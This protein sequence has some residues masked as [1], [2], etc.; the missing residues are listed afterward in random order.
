[1]EQ[2]LLRCPGKAS[3]AF[4]I[5]HCSTRDVGDAADASDAERSRTWVSTID[6][7]VLMAA[8]WQETS[9]QNRQQHQ[10]CLNAVQYK[11]PLPEH[12]SALQA[13]KNHTHEVLRLQEEPVCALPNLC[14]SRIQACWVL[15][16]ADNAKEAHCQSS[17]NSLIDDTA[18]ARFTIL[19]PA[20]L[21]GQ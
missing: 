18:F 9:P 16:I 20:C 21:K 5:G 13:I 8:C 12:P 10:H 4:R 15:W 2:I 14:A 19:A 11:R 17:I 3:V 1:M 6:A 7:V